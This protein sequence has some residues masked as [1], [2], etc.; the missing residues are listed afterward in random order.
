MNLIFVSLLKGER[1][2]FVLIDGFWKNHTA[3]VIYVIYFIFANLFPQ[4]HLSFTYNLNV[5]THTA[6]NL[7]NGILIFLYRI[8]FLLP[9]TCRLIS[10]VV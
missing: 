7:E 4:K 3:T 5:D 6:I 9:M 8:N 1:D 2:E 10:F